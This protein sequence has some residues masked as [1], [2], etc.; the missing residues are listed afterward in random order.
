[1]YRAKEDGRSRSAV[2]AEP[3]RGS[4]VRRLDTEVSLRRALTDGQLEVH[5]QPVLELATGRMVGTEALVRWQHP[6]RGLLQPVDFIGVAESSGH[7]VDIGHWVLQTAIAELE[8]WPDGPPRESFKVHV[9]LLPVEVRWPGLADMVAGAL[10]EHA[11]P[12][13]QLV[14]EISE[15]GLMTGD[16]GDLE[17][18]L[19]LRRL[20]VGIAIDDFGT[21]YSSISY[22]RR[23]PIDSVKVDQSLIADITA[24]PTQVRFVG[25]I[26][27]LIEAAGLAAVVEGI[28]S[29]EQMRT[30]AGLGC[31]Y[32]Q[33]FLFGKPG[34]WSAIMT[35]LLGPTRPAVS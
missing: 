16:V 22:L 6:T 15:T 14:L 33:G 10:R 28:E 27:Q 8:H 4:A 2:F 25:A 19:A 35:S 30:L 13:G 32:G 1:M 9:N 7:I 11:V 3:M 20:G 31:R 12:A 21:G 29:L 34:P 18:L 23:L 26:L 17:A 5:Y 24:D